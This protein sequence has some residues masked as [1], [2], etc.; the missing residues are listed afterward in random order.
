MVGTKSHGYSNLG[1]LSEGE[2]S[3]GGGGVTRPSPNFKSCDCVCN[4]FYI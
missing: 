1:W 2:Y 3:G 4:I